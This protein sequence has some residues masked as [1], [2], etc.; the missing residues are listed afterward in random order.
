MKAFYEYSVPNSCIWL[1]LKYKEQ[2]PNGT[3]KGLI[4]SLKI[5]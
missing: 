2:H 3:S 5:K 4:K 1:Y